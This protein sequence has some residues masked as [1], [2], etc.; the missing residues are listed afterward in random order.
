MTNKKGHKIDSKRED[1]DKIIAAI[2]AIIIKEEKNGDQKDKAKNSILV[3]N[4]SSK[5]PIFIKKN[6]QSPRKKKSP[7]ETRIEQKEKLLDKTAKTEILEGA[8]EYISHTHNLA[9]K[10]E[11]MDDSSEKPIEL[12]QRVYLEKNIDNKKIGSINYCD[13]EENNNDEILELTDLRKEGKIPFGK[14][15]KN[16]KRSIDSKILVESRPAQHSQQKAKKVDLNNIDRLSGD[17][18]DLKY[19]LNQLEERKRQKEIA[20]KELPEK[21]QQGHTQA[22][23]TA[24]KKEMKETQKR[25]EHDKM[26][27][28]SAVVTKPFL[29]RSTV[30]T[31]SEKQGQ[32]SR[33]VELNPV[34]KKQKKQRTTSRLV[35]SPQISSLAENKNLSSTVSSNQKQ[36]EKDTLIENIK[37]SL[38]NIQNKKSSTVDQAQIV[39]EEKSSLSDVVQNNIL[40]NFIETL[41]KEKK[42]EV[43]KS[44]SNISVADFVR[45]MI[46]EW[47][48]KN[49]NNVVQE[50]VEKEIKNIIR[51][52]K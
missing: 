13:S 19:L 24:Q 52:M 8:N 22:I 29:N 43:T 20:N 41:E 45:P 7:L 5:K 46:K 25:K 38:K 49:L 23:K 35:D 2:E 17:Y 50:T 3:K 30:S 9:E 26:V 37:K 21:K 48:E 6:S 4:S 42:P 10:D 40:N 11:G 15:K 36:I 34:F 18:A 51:Q 16:E 44:L 14:M 31:P 33:K 32:P 47:L 1:M 27:V 39:H 28:S 12:T